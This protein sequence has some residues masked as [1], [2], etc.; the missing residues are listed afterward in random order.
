MPSSPFTKIFGIVLSRPITIR[1]PILFMF[2][3]FSILNHSLIIIIIITIIFSI[4]VIY[5]FIYFSSD[6]YFSSIFIFFFRFLPST[7]SRFY[8]YIYIM[9]VL[10]S[11]LALSEHEHF[12]SKR[13]AFD[14]CI[15]TVH[16]R[17][18]SFL[19]SLLL[20][21]LLIQETTN[22]ET[23]FFND[24]FFLLLIRR[25]KSRCA[26]RS[27]RELAITNAFSVAFIGFYW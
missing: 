19:L 26:R 25:F 16:S 9:C 10:I 6:L 17:S 4:I 13:L 7:F 21:L 3:T 8:F 23:V 14:L 27:R 12:L 15:F 20:L 2:H 22:V 24:S 1:I 18:L 11:L 5:L